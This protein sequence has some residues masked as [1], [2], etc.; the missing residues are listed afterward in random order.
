M[1]IEASEV[2]EGY[3][4]LWRWAKEQPGMT[5]AKLMAIMVFALADMSVAAAEQH[6]VSVK[7]SADSIIDAFQK[8][9]DTHKYAHTAH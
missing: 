7:R 9:V 5:P 2:K 4:A 1:M 8:T 6:N 3:R